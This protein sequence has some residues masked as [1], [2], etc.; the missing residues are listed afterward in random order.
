MAGRQTSTPTNAANTQPPRVYGVS[1]YQQLFQ[2]GLFIAAG[3]R[4]IESVRVADGRVNGSERTVIV[5]YLTTETTDVGYVDEMI[6]IFQAV[7]AT[8]QAHDLDIDS[9]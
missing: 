2:N 3:G 4:H 9:V 6:D 8:V 5:A 7:A 1:D